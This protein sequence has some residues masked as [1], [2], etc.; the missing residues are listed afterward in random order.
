MTQITIGTKVEVQ[1]IG[2]EK[3]GTVVKIGRTRATIEVSLADGRKVQVMR[4]IVEVEAH[5]AEKAQ[6]MCRH[7]KSIPARMA[8]CCIREAREAAERA[9][10]QA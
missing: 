3:I 6:E 8:S 5:Q 4:S 9:Q 7:G 10:V 1:H 2:I